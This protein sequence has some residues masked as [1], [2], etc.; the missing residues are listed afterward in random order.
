LS[1]LP[2]LPLLAWALVLLA[3]YGT[4]LGKAGF[5][6]AGMAAMIL[7][8]EIFPARQS[9]GIILP[10]LITADILAVWRFRKFAV[11]KHVFRILPPAFV[12]VVLG[13]WLMPRVPEQ[14]FAK[15]IGGIVLVMVVLLVL[16]RMLPR[17]RN[18]TLEHQALLIP[19][20][21]AA[22]VTTMMANAAG[23]ITT[24][25]LL[26]C[27]LPKME[28]VGT[29]AWFFLIV[30]V[31]KVPFSANLGLITPSS[32]AVNLLV[33]PAIVLGIFSGRWILDRISQGVFEWLL[34]AFATLG[35]LRLA[36]V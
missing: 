23:P 24:L 12:G 29:G 32:L 15:V 22:G 20:G 21:L 3:G 2:E 16:T 1:L 28:F 7:M 9:T 8:A 33:V 6:G 19:T 11:W 14:G 30:N 35:A 31:L 36:L 18:L 5:G 10:M 27:R 34:I 13:W 4:G 17:L 26:A 25:Y